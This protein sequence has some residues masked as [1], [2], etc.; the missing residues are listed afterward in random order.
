MRLLLLFL[1]MSSGL[2]SGAAQQMD[3]AAIMAKVAAHQDAGIAERRHFL[4]VQHARVSSRTG[5]TIRCEE[6]TYTRVAPTENGYVRQL[7]KLDGR[8]LVKGSYVTYDSLPKADS[9]GD[10]REITINVDDQDSMD[11]DLVEN[12]RHNLTEDK[13]KDGIR[14]GLFPLTS[15]AQAGYVYRLVKRETMNGRD[16]FHITFTP[17]D[18]TDY[19]WRGD[20]WIDTTAY[21]PVLVRTRLAKNVPFAVRTLLGT[22]VPGLG[23]TV[24][25]APQA[26]PG[27]QQP[28]WFPVSFG[29]EF[30]LNVLF[31]LRREITVNAENRNF[32]R[33]HVTSAI[34]PASSE[35]R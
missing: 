28:V 17:K 30:H 22:S 15:E 14:A 32:E 12:M 1:V 26:V 3:A 21:E 13:S 6:V 8:L 18:K 23:F 16:V 9:K 24:V 4:Y 19:D 11:R 29:T 5:K 27:E 34:M 35:S 10:A 20:A 2:R 33:T 25:F 7:L 31:F